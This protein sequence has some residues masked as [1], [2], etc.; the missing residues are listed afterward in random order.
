M[1]SQSGSVGYTIMGKTADLT[2]VQKTVTS[3]LCWAASC[4]LS[5]LFAARSAVFDKRAANRGSVLG[6]QFAASE[7]TLISASIDI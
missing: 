5:H 4:Q 3:H 6:C 1:V 7:G 2:D